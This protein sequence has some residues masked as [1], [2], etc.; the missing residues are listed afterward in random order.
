MAIK[1]EAYGKI[2]KY[3]AK[4]RGGCLGDALHALYSLE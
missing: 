3:M 2:K 4:K 1:K